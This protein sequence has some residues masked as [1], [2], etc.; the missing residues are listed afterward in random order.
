M[1]DFDAEIKFPYGSKTSVSSCV[2][3]HNL[4]HRICGKVDK[5]I[6]LKIKQRVFY[7]GNQGLALQFW[8]L[9]TLFST[10]N[11]QSCLGDLHQARR[12]SAVYDPRRHA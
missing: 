5:L 7:Y 9:L 11:V 4:I 6:C 2:L 8:L 1:P 3:G 10:I 12:V